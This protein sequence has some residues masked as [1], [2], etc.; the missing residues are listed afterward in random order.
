MDLTAEPLRRRLPAVTGLARASRDVAGGLA[1][2]SH[3]GLAAAAST[4][5]AGAFWASIVLP[6]LHVPLLFVVGLSGSTTPALV[7]LWAL[8]ATALALGASHDPGRR[9]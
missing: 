3:R 9:E 7:T 4:A 1:D 8:H 2:A 5:R 6:F